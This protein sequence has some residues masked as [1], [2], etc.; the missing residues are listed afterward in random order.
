MVLGL[1]YIIF[2]IT[3]IFLL[4][5]DKRKRYFKNNNDINESISANSKNK[6]VSILIVLCTMLMYYIMGF[7]FKIDILNVITWRRNSFSIS[8]IGL[9]LL[10]ITSL[11][12]E[13]IIDVIKKSR[14]NM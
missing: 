10:I 5:K 12:I 4:V 6:K 14:H 11:L 7:I 2:I 1:I 3:T 13:F 9:I 8:F